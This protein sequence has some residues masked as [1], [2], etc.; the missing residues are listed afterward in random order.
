MRVA[1]ISAV[2]NE[3]KNLP[4]LL[5]A[6]TRQ[7]QK[8]D[9]FILVD[10]GSTDGTEEMMRKG[11]PAGR[12]Y[13][14]WVNYLRQENKGPA[15]ARNAGWRYVQADICIFIDGDCVPE[16]DWIERLV[17]PFSSPEAGASAGTYKTLNPENPLARFIGLEIAWRYRHKPREV[18]AHGSYNLAVRRTALEEIGGFREDY[19]APSGED[20]DLTYKISRRS[21]IIFIPE[22]VVGH[23]HPERFW[24]YLKNQVRR[25]YDRIKVYRDHPDKARGD[26]YTGRTAQYPIMAAALLPPSLACANAGLPHAGILCWILFAVISAFS[27]T[28]FGYYLSKDKTAALLSPAIQF[29]RYFAWAL[30]ACLGV[31]RFGFPRKAS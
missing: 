27:F 24:P 19:P 26:T 2:Y 10:D 28:G 6:L 30:G 8:P 3:E 29:S 13:P 16:P 25:A 7:T 4:A 17:K 1:V 11:D 18:D 9:Q 31:M 22:A 15:S 12:P 5:E 23:Y 20:W 14:S 21:K